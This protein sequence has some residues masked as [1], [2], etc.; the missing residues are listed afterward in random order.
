MQFEAFH[1]YITSIVPV[2]TVFLIV[3][4]EME[5]WTLC[6]LKGI[7]NNP[8]TQDCLVQFMKWFEAGNSDTGNTVHLSTKK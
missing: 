3:R 5:H 2:I 7:E 8:Q 1:F 4:E 6:H